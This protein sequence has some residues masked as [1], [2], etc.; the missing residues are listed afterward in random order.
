MMTMDAEIRAGKNA[1]QTK[2]MAGPLLAH[3]K[4]CAAPPPSHKMLCSPQ[5]N[6][7]LP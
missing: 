7:W 6:A 4:F 3:T 5:E 1:Y 2:N